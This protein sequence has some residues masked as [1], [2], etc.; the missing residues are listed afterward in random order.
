MTFAQGTDAFVSGNTDEA[1]RGMDELRPIFDEA[2]KKHKITDEAL[3]GRE[4]QVA[5]YYR[6][7]LAH[8]SE[9]LVLMTY[10]V[11]KGVAMSHIITG[12]K[13]ATPEIRRESLV[14]CIQQHAE[15]QRQQSA[16]VANQPAVAK[17]IKQP[18]STMPLFHPPFAAALA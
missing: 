16:N 3:S 4:P 2:C 10:L 12:I 17:E 8:P 18:V 14:L 11:E 15:Y 7:D 6:T 1:A 9:L 5:L 13:C